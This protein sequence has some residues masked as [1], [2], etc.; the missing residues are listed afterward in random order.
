MRVDDLLFYLT[1]SSVTW[2]ETEDAGR[3]REIYFYLGG[4]APCGKKEKDGE[5]MQD[6]RENDLLL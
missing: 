6:G 2:H 3:M 4:F 1:V 5:N